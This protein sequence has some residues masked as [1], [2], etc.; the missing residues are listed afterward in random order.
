MVV[1]FWVLVLSDDD[2][3]IELVP[4]IILNPAYDVE[5]LELDENFNDHFAMRMNNNT[6]IQP[7]RVW[8]V[9]C[10]RTWEEAFILLP[11]SVVITGA[12]I[13]V[14]APSCQK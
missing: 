13:V 12:V 6:V 4:N 11:A 7:V 5:H 2:E 10:L 9:S 14:I 8:P 1:N 3:I